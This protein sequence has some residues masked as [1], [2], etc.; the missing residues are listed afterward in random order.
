MRRFELTVGIHTRRWGDNIKND[1]KEAV[2]EDVNWIHLAQN[3][4]Q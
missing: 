4:D 1:L 3:K 2:C